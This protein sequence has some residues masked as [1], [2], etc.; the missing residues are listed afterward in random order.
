MSVQRKNILSTVV[1]WKLCFPRHICPSFWSQWIFSSVQFSHSVVSDSLRP[2]E[3][4][5]AKP[6]VHHQLPE[7]TQTHVHWVGDAIQPSHLLLSPSPTFNLSQHQGIF[8]WVSSSHHVPKALVSA[9][10]S[11]IPMNIQD[12]FPLGLTGWFSLLSKGLSRVFSQHHTSKAS[13]LRCSAFFTVQLS[14]RDYWKNY[15]C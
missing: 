2:H 14:V 3:L 5:H 9:S 12:W 11:V 6:L 1:G 10:A 13:I 4:Q 15:S 7:F 8:Q